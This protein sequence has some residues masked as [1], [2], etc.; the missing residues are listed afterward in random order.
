M[1]LIV[2]RVLFFRKRSCYGLTTL[3]IITVA[4]RRALNGM[5]KVVVI[6]VRHGVLGGSG[7]ST[8]NFAYKAY[9]GT[10]A[11]LRMMSNVRTLNWNML[12][13]RGTV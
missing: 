5:F 12:G 2:S 6:L 8:A 13:K 1:F 7:L 11:A 9:C 10:T 3:G 4:Q